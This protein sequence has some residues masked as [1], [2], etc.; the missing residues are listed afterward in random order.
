MSHAAQ[1]ESLHG[2]LA[3]LISERYAPAQWRID[4]F[5]GTP[6][7]RQ[8]LAGEVDYGDF[9]QRDTE[10]EISPALKAWVQRKVD[11]ATAGS[12]SALGDGGTNGED[13]KVRPRGSPRFEAL[14][15]AEQLRY[16][17]DILLPETLLRIC[18][19]SLD[20]DRPSSWTRPPAEIS[21]AADSGPPP[22]AEADGSSD[23]P[24]AKAESTTADAAEEARLYNLARKKL[25]ELGEE[26]L[27]RQWERRRLEVQ[28][29]QK[30]AR[31][32]L[33]LSEQ[34]ETK[35]NA[36]AERMLRR[37]AEQELALQLAYDRMNEK[38]EKGKKGKGKKGKVAEGV[39]S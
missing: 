6:A 13:A 23:G 19:C 1:V 8:S 9:T 25:Q 35:V 16:T 10:N 27:P 38:K 37:D 3:N 14:T 31:A 12:S 4:L 17:E 18:L 5:F 26:D 30:A 33:G 32:R 36:R 22:E 28:M 11:D 15:P 20:L 7:Q 24:G 29:A 39:E 34:R 21:Q 2:H